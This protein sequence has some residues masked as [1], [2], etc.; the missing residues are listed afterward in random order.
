MVVELMPNR[1]KIDD[2][3]TLVKGAAGT[4]VVKKLPVTPPVGPG[5]GSATGLITHPPDAVSGSAVTVV[6]QPDPPP[7][8]APVKVVEP[9]K[10]D[11]PPDEFPCLKQ[12]PKD[13][14]KAP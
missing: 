14:P 11:C 3:E 4:T 2:K 5:S 9:P 6:K 1:P 10:P 12:M 13:T 8:D 7:V